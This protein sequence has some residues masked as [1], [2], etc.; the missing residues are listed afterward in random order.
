MNEK[1]IRV[2]DQVYAAMMRVRSPALPLQPHRPA[3]FSSRLASCATVPF[4]VLVTEVPRQAPC[5][6]PEQRLTVAH[7]CRR[8]ASRSCW[9]SRT[10]SMAA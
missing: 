7:V 3:S 9:A 8:R 2:L 4:S 5:P 1:Q 6:T 10:S